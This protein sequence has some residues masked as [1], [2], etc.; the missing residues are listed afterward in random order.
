[1]AQPRRD[2]IWI[3]FNQ[4][5][6][7][8]DNAPLATMQERW[9]HLQPMYGFVIA[10]HRPKDWPYIL[11]TV[12]SAM[13]GHALLVNNEDAQRLVHTLSYVDIHFFII[14]GAKMMCLSGL[15]TEQL[16]EIH[17]WLGQQPAIFNQFKRVMWLSQEP[18]LKV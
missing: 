1:M 12:Q 3:P 5:C 9:S 15:D 8:L 11:N 16:L 4:A 7:E 14:D 6:K 13:D 17:N 10:V 18:R 2:R